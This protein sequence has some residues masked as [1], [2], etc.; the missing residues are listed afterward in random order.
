VQPKVRIPEKDR[1][2]IAEAV[3]LL[4]KRALLKERNQVKD[5]H[6]KALVEVKLAAMSEH[7][8]SRAEAYL[9]GENRPVQNLQDAA[10]KPGDASEV[11]KEWDAVINEYDE[12]KVKWAEPALASEIEFQKAVVNYSV[13]MTPLIEAFDKAKSSNIP[14]VKAKAEEARG[15]LSAAQESLIPLSSDCSDAQDDLRD[16][17]LLV[18]A[19]KAKPPQTLAEVN[20]AR[21]RFDEA[22]QKVR[23][24]EQA[25]EAQ[26]TAINKLA[27]KQQKAL[28]DLIKEMVAA[29]VAW[30]ETE[31]VREGAEVVESLLNGVVNAAQA[32]DSEPMSALAIQGLHSLIKGLS[33]GVKLSAAGIKSILLK[34]GHKD[35]MGLIDKLEA[36][37]F[38]QAKL[39]LIKMGLS[40]LVEP[41]GLIPNVGAIVRSAANLGFGLVVGTLKKAAAKQAAAKEKKSG[42]A[43]VDAEILE[44][45]EIIRESALGYVKS[46]LEGSVKALA[47]PEEAAGEFLMS[48]LGEVLGPPLER[49]VAEVV[50]EFDLVDKEQV[51]ATVQDARDAVDKQANELKAMTKIDKTFGFNEEVAKAVTIKN[52]DDLS[53]G[54]SCSVVV[55]ASPQLET[56]RGVALL[57]GEGHSA[58]NLSFADSLVKTGQGCKGDVLMKAKGGAVF[59]GELVFTFA[60]K[61]AEGEAWVKSYI[62]H[63][64]S[65]LT[66]KKLTFA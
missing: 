34:K 54:Q 11:S 7:I 57:I 4:K 43:N 12:K 35:V 44:A 27:N 47:K 31:N 52:L 17:F 28:E 51:K 53:Q 22:I 9:Q 32:L 64:G 41:L 1:K 56:T 24:K 36:D 13:A 39:D 46:V 14:L 63:Y 23:S 37:A 40:W 10:R 5:F 62:N 30:S 29:A 38:I 26:V 49:I 59:A 60:D 16:F 6:K 15:T 55:A 50:G 8:R 65:D 61:K 42:N 25:I 18:D 58:D 3:L 45:A 2:E 20:G 21:A 48:V 19:L 33:D 66:K